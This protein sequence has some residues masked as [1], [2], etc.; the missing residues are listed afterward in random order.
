MAIRF[1]V[2]VSKIFEQIKMNEFLDKKLRQSK[3]LYSN[4]WNESLRDVGHN[5]SNQKDDYN[6]NI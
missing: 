2:S 4:R 6:L 1:A 5:D 3:I